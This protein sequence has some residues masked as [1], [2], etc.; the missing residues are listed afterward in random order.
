MKLA[1]L[2]RA[3]AIA[4]AI[5]GAAPLALADGGGGGGSMNTPQQSGQRAD[6]AAAYQQGVTALQAQ[7]YRTAIRH[8]R[9]AR[10][11]APND[12]NINY[13]LGLALIGAD[14][15][16][17][18]RDALER[19]VRDNAAPAAAWLQLGLVYLEL[20]QRDR[21]VAQQAALAA[22]V[23]ACD[24]ACGDARRGQLQAAHDQLT[25]ALEATAAPAAADPATTGWNFPSAEEGRAAYAEAVGLINQERFAEA[26]A[27]LTRAQTAVGPHPDVLNYMGFTSRKLGRLDTSLSYYRQALAIDPNHLGANE[28]LG[29][30]Y[31][32]MGDIPRARAQLARLDQLCAYGCAQREELARWI[33][34]AR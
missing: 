9:T 4:L 12:P 30:L 29:E 20:N 31:I 25:R 24:A 8:F 11:G 14:E 7:D 3:A 23:S 21:A 5:A 2:T 19:A 17:E 13:A 34:A 18:A 10:R 16:E 22:A 33:E 1:H 27:A 26:F 15:K 28:Y 32:Q 6:P